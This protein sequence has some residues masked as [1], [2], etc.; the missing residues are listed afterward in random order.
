MGIRWHL[1]ALS[2]GRNQSAVDRE[3]FRSEVKNK[4]GY[5]LCIL[6]ACYQNS[7]RDCKS[8]EFAGLLVLQ[9]GFCLGYNYWNVLRQYQCSLMSIWRCLPET[10]QRWHKRKRS[11]ADVVGHSWKNYKYRH[12]NDVITL[13]RGKIK[14]KHGWCVNFTERFIIQTAVSAWYICHL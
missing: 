8:K 2:R 11:A 6:E 10:G 12:V 1:Q 7:P 14:N 3:I 9:L 4:I 5:F 13:R